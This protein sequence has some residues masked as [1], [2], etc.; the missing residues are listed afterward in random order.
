MRQ[1]TEVVVF[2]T[3]CH[4]FTA[5]DSCRS[6]EAVYLNGSTMIEVKDEITGMKQD[7]T[8]LVTTFSMGRI[9]HLLYMFWL[10]LI[11]MNGELRRGSG[12]RRT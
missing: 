3:N 8:P 1:M 12:S 7:K 9:Y 2:Q 6:H 10:L 4:H 11:L 5:H